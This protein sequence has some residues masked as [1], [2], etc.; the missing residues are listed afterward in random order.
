[1]TTALI[2]EVHISLNTI[3]AS[4]KKKPSYLQVMGQVMTGSDT[5]LQ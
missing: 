3:V 4:G 1:M 2:Q 5:A